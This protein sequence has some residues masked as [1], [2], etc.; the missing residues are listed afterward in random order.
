[1]DSFR[2]RPSSWVGKKPAAV[3]AKA[4]FFL[5]PPPEHNVVY[6]FHCRRAH[7]VD[8]FLAGNLATPEMVH[9]QLNPPCKPPR[10]RVPNTRNI[11][12]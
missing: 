1:M 5:P 8:E 7:S 6:C 10:N 11:D 12:S 3:M 9:A 4:G 2:L